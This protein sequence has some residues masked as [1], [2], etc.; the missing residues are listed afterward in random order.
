[1]K[2]IIIIAGLLL[3]LSDADAQ[4]KQVDLVIDH[5]NIV[6]V[7]NNKI[8]VDQ[9]VY[10]KKDKII[11]TG[12][13]NNLNKKLS[14]K[15]RVVA[16]G[17]YIMPSLWDMHVHFGGDTLVEENKM[18]LPLYT[19]MGISHVR[20]CAGDISL[21]V[22]E[23]KKAIQNNELVGPTIFTSGPK[24]EGIKSIWPGDLE[25]ANE[26]E[27]N[28]ALDSLQKLKVDFI[29]ITD[30]TLSPD[31]FLNSI[32]AAR[33]R[34]WKVSGH[35]PATMNVATFSKNGL[36]AI[37]HIGYLQRA[38]SANEDSITNWRAIG[39]INSREASELYLNSFDSVIAIQ[40]FKTLAANGTA[41]VPTI[42]GSYVTT[43]LDINN[44]Q[45]D[46]YLKYLGPALKRT[47]DWRVKRASN[48]NAEAIQFRHKNFEAAASLL[49]LLYKAG[50]T[51]L[52]GTDAGYLN[53]FNYPGLG[54][55]QELAIMVKYGLSP[56][57]ALICS[58]INGPAFFNQSKDYGAV[59]TNKK[60][61]LL[62]LD[63]N[64]LE[65]IKNTESINGVIRKGVYMDRKKLDSILLDIETAVNKLK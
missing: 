32:I 9:A 41:V 49:P 48:D 31:L 15:Q 18:L 59:L 56:Q 61:D 27:L 17:K 35:V 64:P 10:I 36:S 20:D 6:D 19:A 39:K 65:N 28:K 54:M 52:A 7:V 25:I 33:K 14:A 24:L 29:K 62:I 12:S 40:K 50:V 8:L 5:V 58:I 34:G 11:A 13:S 51:I 3:R 1:M 16:K 42:N 23:W 55:H 46:D 4:V 63:K 45:N 30:N 44:H 53:S 37:E 22:I 43:Y 2:K 60:A 38:A 26:V 21:A 57:Q 47:Y